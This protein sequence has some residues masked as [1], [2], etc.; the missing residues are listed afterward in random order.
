MN[1]IPSQR[2]QECLVRDLIHL[3]F[4]LAVIADILEQENSVQVSILEETSAE[5]KLTEVCVLT[6]SNIDSLHVTWSATLDILG[7]LL[8]LQRKK[9][10]QSTYDETA[11]SYSIM[12]LPTAHAD[13]VW[14]FV[15]DNGE[16]LSTALA[17][18]RKVLLSTPP[19]A[20]PVLVTRTKVSAAKLLGTLLVDWKASS[21]VQL[22]VITEAASL[23]ARAV[24]VHFSRRAQDE[25]LP[26]KDDL[27]MSSLCVTLLCDAIIFPPTTLGSNSSTA[28]IRAASFIELLNCIPLITAVAKEAPFVKDDVILAHVVLR[29]IHATL[30]TQADDGTYPM[31]A[32][33]VNHCAL[34]GI[35]PAVFQ[36]L[37]NTHLADV[38]TKILSAMLSAGTDTSVD[39]ASAC[40]LAQNLYEKDIANGQ[41]APELMSPRSGS[42]RRGRSSQ[43]SP[44]R[45]QQLQLRLERSPKRLR[46]GLATNSQATLATPSPPSLSHSGGLAASGSSEASLN[47]K[48]C[49]ESLGNTLLRALLNAK[50]IVGMVD[51]CR[52][53]FEAGKPSPTS[54]EESA[55]EIS[56]AIIS[57]STGLC[58]LFRLITNECHED[59]DDKVKA[60]LQVASL[61]AKSLTSVAM[62]LASHYKTSNG[63]LSDAADRAVKCVS[64]VGLEGQFTVNRTVASFPKIHRDTITDCLDAISVCAREVWTIQLSSPDAEAAEMVLDRVESNKSKSRICDGTCRKVR[65][66]LS[67]DSGRDGNYWLPC[68]CKLLRLP[69]TL[70]RQRP[71]SSDR[72]EMFQSD[73]TVVLFERLS[74]C[75]RYVEHVNDIGN[76]L[77]FGSHTVLTTISGA[78]SCLVCDLR[79][80]KKT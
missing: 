74:T 37:E 46:I 15:L 36:L 73:C 17:S 25:H 72:G 27:Q 6:F 16:M 58:L 20:K 48:G 45:P 41:G 39:I 40:R 55:D 35:F 21:I 67:S 33:A 1:F 8:K 62:S 59:V 5:C 57:V 79:Q 42:K 19:N 13:L 28:A 10:L 68:L 38:A 53:L 66:T 30:F 22:P 63:T 65:R 29:A 31:I 51:P 44:Y 11:E 12:N 26:T 7:S 9:R 50:H 77:Y 23:V 49:H 4:D 2:L 76:L 61:L 60:L 24:R 70:P 71:S 47:G 43:S 80:R 64:R 78:L 54:S 18:M 75:D 3:A 34:E 32:T 52:V 56:K 14:S 69:D